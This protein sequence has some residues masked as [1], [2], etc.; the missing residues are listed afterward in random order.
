MTKKIHLFRH[1]Q[2]EEQFQRKFMGSSDVGLS[3]EGR[4]QIIKFRPF[5]RERADALFFYSPLLRAADSFRLATEGLTVKA[6]SDDDLREVDFGDW[7]GLT[8]EDI[9]ERY[10]KPL[11]GWLEWDPEFTYPGGENH[12][13]LVARIKR[14]AAR[15]KEADAETVIVFTHG[16]PVRFLTC[17]LLGL[18]PKH[19]ILFS[20]KRGTRTT[21]DVTDGKAVLEEINFKYD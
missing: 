7:E 21:L 8:F 15:L 5:I 9:Q 10:A 12:Q 18:D 1:G 6:R 13:S 2:I 16:G 14:A 17:E 11:H 20:S 3:D 19:Y 4:E